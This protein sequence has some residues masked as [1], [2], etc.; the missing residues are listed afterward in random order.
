MVEDAYDPI[1]DKLD[2]IKIEELP[3]KESVMGSVAELGE[4]DVI[5][6]EF[7]EKDEN[8]RPLMTS[9]SWHEFAM[10]HF[11]DDELIE[12]CPTVDG[13]RRVVELLLGPVVYSGVVSVD[14]AKPDNDFRATVIYKLRVKFTYP[15]DGE[16]AYVKT[17]VDAADVYPGN[18]DLEFARHAAA[19]ASTRAEART[20]R[21][22][23]RLKKIIAAEEATDVPLEES[24]IA[25]SSKITKMQIN[26][27]EVLAKR[28]NINLAIFIKGYLTLKK[29]NK[30]EQIDHQTALRMV[31][32]LSDWQRNQDKIPDKVKGFEPNW[33]SKLDNEQQK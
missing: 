31:A 20:L 5:D 18:C 10:K 9:E 19:T 7:E 8:K 22:A 12:G 14:P 28:N 29:I 3:K 30:L 21:K 1:A 13:L 2:S 15:E 6:A 4:P 32:Q 11:A 24:G 33:R 26:F 16:A 23:L 17:F 27:L 25:E